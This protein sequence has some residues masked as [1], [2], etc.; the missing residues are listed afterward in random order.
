LWK[1]QEDGTYDKFKVEKL[2]ED[3]ENEIIEN[4][5]QD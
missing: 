1:L 3:E 4:N 5:R 2:P